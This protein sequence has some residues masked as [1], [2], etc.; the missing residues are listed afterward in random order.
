MASFAP[1]FLISRL[2]VN[3]G[4][5]TPSSNCLWPR[6]KPTTYEAKEMNA[7]IKVLDDLCSNPQYS[8]AVNSIA[9][10]HVL[11]SKSTQ[12]V[13]R[14]LTM[15]LHTLPNLV[16][17]EL[18]GFVRFHHGLGPLDP[19][20]PHFPSLECFTCDFPATPKLTEFLSRHPTIKHFAFSG[21]LDSEYCF[22]SRLQTTFP[23]GIFRK[24]HTIDASPTAIR[25]FMGSRDVFLPMYVDLV[26]VRAPVTNGGPIYHDVLFAIENGVA[27]NPTCKLPREL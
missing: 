21:R 14:M 16:S 6:Q 1:Q 15:T 19:I 9:V 20:L 12:K 4:G 13:S 23:L 27:Q 17:L 18:T 22:S 5:F 7:I 2:M 8:H 3:A 10:S 24:L 11:A 25:Y 26:R